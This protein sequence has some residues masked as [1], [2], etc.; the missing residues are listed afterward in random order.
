M[1]KSG[2]QLE[3]DVGVQIFNARELGESLKEVAFELI[4]SEGLDIESRWYHGS[5]DVDLFIWKDSNKKIIRQQMTFYG[6]LVEWSA[7]EGLRTGYIIEDET[8][9]MMSGSPLI[10]YDPAPQRQTLDQGLD[11]LGH[12]SC[13]NSQDKLQ[14][15]HCFIK[16]PNFKYPSMDELAL[17]YNLNLHKSFLNFK[18]LIQ[19]WLGLLNKK[20]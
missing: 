19:N 4:Q 12:T 3:S 5:K 2:G 17:R 1:K 20:K 13:L 10:H 16:S 7:H 6:Q 8:S 11:I 15:F 18:T 9:Q 14:I